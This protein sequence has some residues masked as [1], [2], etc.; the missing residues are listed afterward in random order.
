MSIFSKIALPKI[1]S[2]VFDLSHDIKT[3]FNMGELVP[4]A[5]MDVVPGDRVKIS[6]E[7][8]LRFTPLVYPTMHQIYVTT[9]YFYVPNRILWP[10]FD[11]F[12]QD[13][14]DTHTPPYFS[15][16]A[17]TSVGD[18]GDYL[19][20]PTNAESAS[21]V[22]PSALPA[23][24]YIKIYDEY[25]RDQN[26]LPETFQE[27]SDGSNAWIDSAVNS[28]LRKRAW[29]HDY[30]TSCLP[31]AQKGNAVTLP[32]L[33]NDT[34]VVERSV[35][36]G[37]PSLARKVS[38]DSLAG[39]TESITKTTGGTVTSSTDGNIYIDP[40]GTMQ[41]DLSA[42]AVDLNTLRRAFRLQE[43]L[44]RNARGGTRFTELILAHFGVTTGDARVDRPEY[45]GGSKQN[46]VISEV[47]STAQTIDQSSNDVPV[48]HLAGHGISVG[49]GN[50][51]TYNVKEH[52]W[53]MG[54]MSVCPK[55]AYQ[56]GVS[57]KWTRSDKLDYYWPSFAN[58]G[59]Q[60]VYNKEL[61]IEDD[62]DDNNTVFGYIPRYS[63]YKFEPS[64]VSGQARDTLDFI[65]LG[66][67]FTQHPT[68]NQEFIEC[69]PDRRIFA[70]TD[71]NDHTIIGHIFNNVKMIRKM[72]KYGIPQF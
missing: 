16:L 53:I 44:E 27:L 67:Q 69:N 9:H 47:L 49:G 38:D 58:I 25:Y 34:A 51:F 31:W 11:T 32:L 26:I 56:D 8:M 60:E 15:S 50:T 57:R 55:T 35:S 28:A 1:G 41:V 64:R 68:L 33:N 19:G 5:V 23:A 63:E 13:D 14:N 36:P 54:I 66:R 71:V 17:G 40:N 10:N 3:T 21:G 6:C 30:F 48:G 24:A 52:G 72:P 29:H 42:E 65:H 39:T 62:V 18:L 45:I 22:L 20:L 4:T 70:T 43:W 46:M 7:N 59:E 12:L 2:N 37:T 61:F